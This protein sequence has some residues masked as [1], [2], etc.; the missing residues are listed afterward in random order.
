MADYNSKWLGTEIDEAVGKVLNNEVGGMVLIPSAVTNLNANSSSTEILA[1]FGG[2]ENF[3][4]I[5]Q[6]IVNGMTPYV[7]SKSSG[8]DQSSL[9]AYSF[10]NFNATFTSTSW[11]IG[12]VQISYNNN[13]NNWIWTFTLNGTSAS[14][15][16]TFNQFGL[17]NSVTIPY[18]VQQLST[19][20]I[21]QDIINAFGGLYQLQQIGL[22]LSKQ[23]C[24]CIMEGSKKVSLRSLPAVAY[25][26][27]YTNNTQFSFVLTTISTRDNAQNTP[28]YKRWV[29]SYTNSEAKFTV[30]EQEFIVTRTRVRVGYTN[31]DQNTF[32]R[33][34]DGFVESS[35]VPFSGIITLSGREGNNNYQWLSFF[36]F[37]DS[38]AIDIKIIE[39][40]G[41]IFNN[42]T[43]RFSWSTMESYLSIKFNEAFGLGMDL[44]VAMLD[45]CQ[46]IQDQSLINELPSLSGNVDVTIE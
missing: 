43:V 21:S 8:E 44:S 13:N 36:F 34:I 22:R 19:G 10:V 14:L 27:N 24:V 2:E 30:T 15:T 39:K 33:L 18:A 11:T 4:L 9:N 20:A 25:Y 28:Y 38:N 16:K 46:L 37:A 26:C 35:E 12:F 5:C 42:A 3:K 23:N 41:S 1:A 29:I 31:F 45:N 32:Y 17:I 7:G 40:K 6:S